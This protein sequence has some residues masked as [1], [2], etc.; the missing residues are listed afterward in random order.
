MLTPGCWRLIWRAGPQLDVPHDVTPAQLETLLNG[1]L[2]QQEERLPYSFFVHEQQLAEELGTH[3]L[4]N[5]VPLF[6]APLATAQQPIAVR[7]ML[8][9]AGSRQQRP[10]LA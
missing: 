3:L 4:R 1:L 2:A 5:K 8:A 7:A 6:F 9:S 10:A